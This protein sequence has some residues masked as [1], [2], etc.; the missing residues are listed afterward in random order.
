MFGEDHNPFNLDT[1]FIFQLKLR[2]LGKVGA[3]SELH[4][5]GVNPKHILDTTMFPLSEPASSHGNTGQYLRN[6]EGGK[7][8]GN[9]LR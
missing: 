1:P 9:S 5:T 3:L 2:G 8:F 4:Y 6:F 7:A